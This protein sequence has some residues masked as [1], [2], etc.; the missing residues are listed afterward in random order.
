MVSVICVVSITFNSVSVRQSFCFTG[1]SL[2]IP[3]TRVE[4][5]QEIQTLYGDWYSWRL[6]AC[7]DNDIYIYQ[8]LLILMVL[9]QSSKT[10]ATRTLNGMIPELFSLRFRI[11]R[12]KR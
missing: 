1:N 11:H 9:F 6:L 5:F 4:V 12:R 8:L 10:K 2:P 3:A 7:I